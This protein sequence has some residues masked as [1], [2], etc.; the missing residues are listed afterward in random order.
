M[1]NSSVD[2][3]RVD[4]LRALALEGEAVRLVVVPEVGAKIVSCLDRRTGHEY[5]W[6][7]PWVPIVRPDY[8]GPFERY[9]ISG[10]DECFPGIGQCAYPDGPWQG[11]VVPDHGEVWT[12]PWHATL[13][14]DGLRLWTHGVRF[15]YTLEKRLTPTGDGFAM[16]YRVHNPTPY[17]FKCF[18][19]AHPLFVATPRTRVLFPD[20]VRVRLEVS[21]SGR[22]GPLLTEHAWPRTVDR[23]GR[24]VDLAVIGPEGQGEAD[25]LYTTPLPAGWAALHDGASDQ[26]LAFTFDPAQVPLVGLWSNRSGWPTDRPCYNLA[27]EPCSGC[28]DRLDIAVLRGEYQTVPPEGDLNWDLDVH[29]GRGETSLAQLIGRT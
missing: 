28:P 8:A 20:G 9:D 17:P 6:R 11:T 3:T 25:K 24:Q 18:W 19:S 12:L 16:R 5:L 15:P 14:T 26:W 21:R 22:L 7:N 29:L 23:Y 1:G 4:G 2:E 27:L 10:W 13:E